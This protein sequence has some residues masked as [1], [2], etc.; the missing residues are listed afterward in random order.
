MIPVA[1]MKTTCG[2]RITSLE[3]IM[4]AG[5]A[6]CK[7]SHP[8][9]AGYFIQPKFGGNLYISVEMG[10]DLGTPTSNTAQPQHLRDLIGVHLTGAY[11][12]NS[13]FLVLSLS[14][15]MS[16]RTYRLIAGV[17]CPE[18]SRYGS[19]VLWLCGVGSRRSQVSPHE[20]DAEYGH[21]F[22]SHPTL[23]ISL[24]RKG[25]R[26][27]CGPNSWRSQNHQLARL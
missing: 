27:G 20:I 17:D 21:L 7:R 5:I 23:D 18:A 16:R 22:P 15:P 8:T 10:A 6:F 11:L 1:E 4:R 2:T 14:A 25:D 13:K 3:A 9:D 19:K 26:R 12:L 24:T